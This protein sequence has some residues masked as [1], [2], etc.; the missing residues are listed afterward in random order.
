MLLCTCKGDEAKGKYGLA[1]TTGF[2][3]EYPKDDIH[4]QIDVE[5]RTLQAKKDRRVL[6]VPTMMQKCH[7]R[8]KIE[9]RLFNK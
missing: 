9:R 6:T 2:N 1:G 3:L 8:R 4:R 5:A 7:G